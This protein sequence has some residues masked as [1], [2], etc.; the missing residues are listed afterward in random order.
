MKKKEEARIRKQM[1]RYGQA[2]SLWK[3]TWRHRSLLL[4]CLPGI[5]FFLIFS[6]LPMFGIVIAFQ[7]FNVVK[8]F[9]G[10]KFV[11]L[12][13]FKFFFQSPSAP[14]V[15]FN[16][17]YLNTL[18]IITGLI[19]SLT[20]AITLSEVKGKVFKKITQSIA[21][22][23]HFMSWTIVA[24]MLTIFLSSSNG[25]VNKM[26]EALGG[27]SISFYTTPGV[28]PAILVILKAWQ[29][30][31]FGSIV[32]LAA[33]MGI[34]QEIYE[35]AAIDGAT[36]LKTIF[37]I[38]LPMLKSTIVILLIMNVGKIFNG[39]FGMVYALVGSNSVLYP[40][41]DIIDTYVYRSLM[42]LGDMGMSAA[43]GLSQSIVGFIL[44]MITN[45]IAN[46]L[47][48]ESALF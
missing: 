39:D 32:Y 29:G 37:H 47:S 48:P 25:V 30:A 5:L 3:N 10:S 12:R 45:K 6:Y 44:V 19:M 11:G 17:L 43:V 38:T 28:W 46:K 9:F 36:K 14:K 26:I 13:N 41:T 4:L 35:A 24:M 33:I 18:F 20:I 42:E 22:L 16:T 2:E 8:G 21:I 31:G 7:D 23:P 34:D 40:T 27:E 15:I 1:I